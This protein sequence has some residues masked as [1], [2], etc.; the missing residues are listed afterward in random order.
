ML[1]YIAIYFAVVIK[2][3]IFFFDNSPCFTRQLKDLDADT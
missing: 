2:Y 1:S 3:I